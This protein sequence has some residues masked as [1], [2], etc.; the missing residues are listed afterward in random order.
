MESF[1]L[2]ETLEYSFLI[3]AEPNEWSL[4]DWVLN[5]EAHL[6]QRSKTGKPL[7]GTN[8]CRLMADDLDDLV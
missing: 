1:W 6:L 4:D 2:A 5:T 7:T 3:F 8:A